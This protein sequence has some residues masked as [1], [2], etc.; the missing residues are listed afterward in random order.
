[1]LQAIVHTV[2]P[3][4]VPR[5]EPVDLTVD[6]LSSSCQL[7]SATGALDGRMG[8]IGRMGRIAVDSLVAKTTDTDRQ[9]DRLSPSFTLH[10]MPT[11]PTI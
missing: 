10:I 2:Q 1:M 6:N 8:K 3:S 4:D 7:L 5:V 9:D 11:V